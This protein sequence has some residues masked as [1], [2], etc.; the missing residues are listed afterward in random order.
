MPTE[1]FQTSTCVLVDSIYTCAA[2]L[3]RISLGDTIDA[4]IDVRLALLPTEAGR[5]YAV[6]VG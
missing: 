1:A 4:V 3:T 6:V 5:A 2:V